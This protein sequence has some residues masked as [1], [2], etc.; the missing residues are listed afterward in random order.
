MTRQLLVPLRGGDRIEDIL[1][2]VRD[3][4]QREM[5]VVF[6]VHFGSNRF[7]E[8]AAQLLMINSGLPAKFDPDTAFPASGADG[9]S[10]LEQRIQRTAGELRQHGVTIKVK[11]YT[12]SMRRLVRECMENE[13]VKWV[14]MHPARSRIFRGCHAIAAALWVAGSPV[15]IPLLLWFGPNAITGKEVS[16]RARYTRR[17]K[18][19]E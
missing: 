16:R 15:P 2:C 10:N 17:K 6:L 12:G 5:T 7:K 11:F 1:S 18:G 4:A 8:L 14:I 13:P 9:L 19:R 3:I